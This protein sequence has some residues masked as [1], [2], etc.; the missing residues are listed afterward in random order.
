MTAAVKNIDLLHLEISTLC[1]AA[2]PCCP[3]FNANS[4]LLGEGLKLGYISITKFKEWF[5]P[6][7]MS[8][9]KELNFC[10]NHG[11]PGTN[12]D[13][14]KIV[15]YISKFNLDHF[16]FH[17]NGGMK[18]PKYWKALAKA[19]NKCN[20]IVRPVFSVDGLK[21]TNHIYRRNVKWDKL[22]DNMQAFIDEYKDKPNIVWDYLVFKHNQHQIEET[23]KL[24]GKMGISN[25]Q[26]KHPL[27][28]DDG[29]NITPI[30]SLARDG[31]ILYWIDPSDLE[32]FKP[33]YLD[34]D[35]KTVYE[36][37]KL[38]P[39]NKFW[40]NK[41][42]DSPEDTQKKAELDEV[43]IIPRCK[44]HDLYVEFDGT[45]HQCCF[46]A[47]GFYSSREAYYSGKQISIQSYDYLDARDRLG[48]GGIALNL[49]HTTLTKIE[50]NNTL[51]KLNTFTWDKKVSEGKSL[52][53]ATFCGEKQGLDALYESQLLKE[54]LNLKRI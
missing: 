51:K 49:N 28:L 26:F 44:P 20:F 10:G 40:G 27:N 38:T 5:P 47:T 8:R 43:K 42:E 45:V 15:E 17:S 30:P 4:P 23:K 13:F 32:R 46:A 18:T 1:N 9:V 39:L 35:A 24:A 36:K 48:R 14:A 3:R 33:T 12:P 54:S 25:I 53:C 11:D 31:S 19:C 22:M 50:K 29:K 34:K 6:E 37:K 16:Q 2:C 7:V 41:R 52:V 21:D